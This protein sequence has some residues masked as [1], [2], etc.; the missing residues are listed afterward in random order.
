MLSQVGGPRPRKERQRNRGRSGPAR[1]SRTSRASS[2]GETHRPRAARCLASQLARAGEANCVGEA[3]AQSDRRL[4]LSSRLS[5][6]VSAQVFRGSKANRVLPVH[7]L[8]DR[9]QAS[10]FA[11]SGGTEGTKDSDRVRGY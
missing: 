4:W 11:C 7:K 1:E 5:S 3:E 10:V 8:Q 2:G 6:P 9:K